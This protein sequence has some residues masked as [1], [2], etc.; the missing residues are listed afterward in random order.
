MPDGRFLVRQK[1][2]DAYALSVTDGGR[3]VHHL[4][5][6]DGGGSWMVNGKLGPSSLMTIAD[7]VRFYRKAGRWKIPLTVGVARDG[8]LY[9]NTQ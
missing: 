1:A 7:F 2:D 3:V 9:D 8:T 6:H 4:L 5:V